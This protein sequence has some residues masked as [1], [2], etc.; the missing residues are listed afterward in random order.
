MT[1]DT[2]EEI[3]RS[4]ERT[5]LLALSLQERLTRAGLTTMA[6]DAQVIYLEASESV[7]KLE[8]ELGIEPIRPRW[9][10][11]P[12]FASLRLVVS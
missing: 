4:A 11:Q 12:Q 1:R 3:F 7:E 2:A 8:E 9:E 6:R 5:S 10:T